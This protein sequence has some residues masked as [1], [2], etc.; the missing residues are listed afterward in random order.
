MPCAS[1][2]LSWLLLLTKPSKFPRGCSPC[3]PQFAAERNGTVTL[4]HFGERALW[5][6]SSSGCARISSPKSQRFFCS[7][8]S[9][10]V[11]SP[12]TSAPVTRLRGPRSPRPYCTVFTCMSY[13]LAQ[14]VER[15]PPWC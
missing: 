13:Q 7:S 10:S 14:N 8:R 5:Y 4:S 1:S 6:S 3:P 2:H 15:I 12:H 9:D 11:S